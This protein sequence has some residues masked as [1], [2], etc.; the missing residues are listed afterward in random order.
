MHVK[1]IDSKK[2]LLYDRAMKEKKTIILK[3]GGSVITK[4]ELSVPQVETERLKAIAN[5]L[6]EYFNPEEFRLILIHGAGSFG[7]VLAK[8]YELQNGTKDHPEKVPQALEVQTSV[9]SLHE[10]FM[11]IFQSAGLPVASFPTHIVTTNSQGKLATIATHSLREALEKNHM[12]VLYG[13]MIP[14]SEWG[15]SIC[16][17]DVL[18]ARLAK[19]L[20]ANSVFFA[21]DVDGIFTS[22]PHL[23]P[24]AQLI[25]EASLEDILS[26]TIRLDTSHNIDVTGGLGSKFLLFQNCPS[27]KSIYLF[28]G[29]KPENFSFVFDERQKLGTCIKATQ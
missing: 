7:H 25:P 11:N 23:H 17:G 6:R 13:D 16:S 3:L 8:K 22:D 12:P 26:G 18:A 15:Y 1:K 29:L 9:K 27:L 20:E 19:D 10:V 28:N 2:H 5:S 14:D 24:E 21:S 4:K